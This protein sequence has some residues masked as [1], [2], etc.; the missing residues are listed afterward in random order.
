MWD[1]RI[2]CGLAAVL[3]LRGVGAA[4]LPTATAKDLNLLYYRM[5]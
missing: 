1:L 2:T 4:D 5:G 3:V